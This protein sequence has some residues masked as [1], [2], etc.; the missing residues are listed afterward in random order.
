M[1]AAGPPDRDTALRLFR[2]RFLNRTDIVAILA[3]WGKP[4][5][6]APKDLD[7]L[8]AAHLL[9]EAAPSTKV[10]WKN[11]GGSTATLGRF[12]VGAYAPAPDGTTR[13]LCL[14]F[15]GAGHASAL[16]DPEEAARAGLAA[17]EQA[18]LTAHL[19]RSGG[20]LG[21][22]LWCFF[23][24]PVPAEEAR[25]IGHALAPKDAPLAGGG[26]ADS[27]AGTG[28]EVFPKQAKV[29]RGGYGNLVWLP[30]WSRAKVGG[31][32]FYRAGPEGTLIPC[33]PSLE[34]ASAERLRSV[35]AELAGDR[36]VEPMVADRPT[37]PG[38]DPTAADSPRWTE[39]RRNALAALPLEPIYGPWLTG[40]TSGVGWLECRDPASQ[41]GDQNPSAGVADGTGQAARGTF[42]SFA[43]NQRLSVFD[44]LVKHCGAANFRA[45]RARVA[46]LAGVPEPQ[47]PTKPPPPTAR[48]AKRRRP[49]RLIVG[50][51]VELGSLALTD[52]K[53]ASP[54]PIV[55]DRGDLFRYEPN[56]GLYVS[57]PRHE[58]EQA[59]HQFDAIPYGDPAKA[60]RVKQPD[61]TGSLACAAARAAQPGFFDATERGIAFTNGFLMVSAAGAVLEPHSPDHRATVGVPH[62]YEPN[63]YP[64]LFS[65]FLR[66][67]FRDDPDKVEKAALLQEFSGACLIGEAT[68][69][70][71]ALILLGLGEN[72]KSVFLKVLQALFPASARAAIPIQMF[73]QEYRRARLAGKLLNAV[74]ELPEADIIDSEECKA[75][76]TGDEI[77][78]RRIREAPFDFK[79]VA[80]HVFSCNRLP[81]TSDHTHGFWRRFTIITFNRM[82]SRPDGWVDPD[83]DPNL[84][85]TIIATELPA[86]LSWAI[87]GAMR[88]LRAG[89]YTAPPSG[90]EALAKWRHGADNVA[91]WL[92]DRAVADE[93]GRL[94]K[95][96][97]TASQRAY[98]DFRHWCAANGHQPLNAN[99]WAARLEGLGYE[100]VVRHA[101]NF[102]TFELRDL[103]PAYSARG[104]PPDYHEEDR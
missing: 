41:T 97:A 29:R 26:F 24:P 27:G 44:F 32:H 81:G 78:G 17:F 89:K 59:I 55:F 75:I 3:P 86:I 10:S 6:A 1:T 4:C 104:A 103:P 67:V 51:H 25:N 35:L 95:D 72:G 84:A 69:F 28:I 43:S 92:E 39:W 50:S 11:R 53:G 2:Q 13:W 74:A 62:P 57:I 91:R 38:V 58:K 93:D 52:L 54:M 85:D 23:D 101:G 83:R 96:G 40:K 99:K 12:R 18:C 87:D 68:R 42:H 56:A 76:I 60:L 47:L 48:D 65:K 80:G 7:A 34:V 73:G 77:E 22:H 19:E 20:G 49:S 90:A 46:E 33:V 31:N 79:P 5:P 102:W 45:A 64:P 36:P 63:L 15:D 82:F 98:D 21:W 9:G 61:V 8:L 70:Q 100:K 16:A 14:D 94:R 66:D 88:A 37:I 30:W 71:I